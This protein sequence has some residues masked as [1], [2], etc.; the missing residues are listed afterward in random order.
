MVG[1]D[2]S[3]SGVLSGTSE[4]RIETCCAGYAACASRPPFIAERCLRIALISPIGA[5]ERTSA[6]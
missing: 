4:I 1:P 5:P 6:R 2:A 3:A